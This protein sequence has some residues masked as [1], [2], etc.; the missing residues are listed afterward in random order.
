PARGPVPKHARERNHARPSADEQHG[1]PIIH[2]PHEMPADWTTQLDF[3][4]DRDSVEEERRYLSVLQQLDGELDT[5]RAV[6]CGRDGVAALSFVPVRRGQTHVHV[7]PW[8]EAERP[9][10]A[11]EKALDHRGS[12]FDRDYG[13]W[14]PDQLHGERRS[15]RNVNPRSS[16][17]LARDPRTCGSR[18]A[19]RTRPRRG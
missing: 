3:V 10:Q 5:I 9:R 18:A 14:L 17:A 19:P 8:D 15:K 2:R 12:R 13:R 11:K 4:S 6:W 1:S 7:L 16:A